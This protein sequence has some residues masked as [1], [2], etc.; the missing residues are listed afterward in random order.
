MKTLT[1]HAHLFPYNRENVVFCDSL[2]EAIQAC[3]EKVGNE[4]IIP[5]EALVRYEFGINQKVLT[6]Q[7]NGHE[8]RPVYTH[9]YRF[10]GWSFHG[11]RDIHTS[12][13]HEYINQEIKQ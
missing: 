7:L 11:W 12:L 4:M 6:V 5:P 1:Y 3:G 9:E 13:M 8:Y 2:S 10:H